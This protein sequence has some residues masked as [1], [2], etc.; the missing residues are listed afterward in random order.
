MRAIRGPCRTF[1]LTYKP[2][3]VKKWHKM[4]VETRETGI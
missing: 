3:P 1:V 4:D 2:F